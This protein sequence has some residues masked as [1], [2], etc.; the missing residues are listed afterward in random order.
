MASIAG[1]K[2]T[3]YK[4]GNELRK[5]TTDQNGY[6]NVTNLADGSYRIVETEAAAGYKAT[7]QKFNF[8]VKNESVVGGVTTFHVANYKETVVVVTKRD[9]DDGTALAEPSYGSWMKTGN[10]LRG[11]DG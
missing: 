6:A 4:D 8:T 2:F 7:S 10:C 3:V 5:V 9:G 1:V 11:N